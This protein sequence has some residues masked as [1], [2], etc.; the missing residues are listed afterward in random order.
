ME[1]YLKVLKL[2]VVLLMGVVFFSCMKED[3]AVPADNAAIE[4]RQVV[5]ASGLSSET[6]IYGVNSQ[7]ELVT[8]KFG[9][10]AQKVGSVPITGL[11]SG[12]VVTALDVRPRTGQLYGFTN[13]GNLYIIDPATGAATLVSKTPISPDLLGTVTAASFDPVTDQLRIVT[14]TG[15]NYTIDPATGMV[16]SMD[17]TIYPATAKINGIAYGRGSQDATISGTPLYAI[18]TTDGTL[19]MLNQ[20]GALTTIGST[21]WLMQG[22]GGFDIANTGSYALAVMNSKYSQDIYA[23]K[24]DYLGEYA[25]RLMLI[26][27]RS[28]K[29]NY[30]GRTEPM[31]AMAI[32]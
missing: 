2:C 8:Y 13:Q 16:S 29:V 31:N 15:K 23:S 4:E 20:K 9:N 1:P 27:L 11:R 24:T 32:K 18:N 30:F 28:G 14:E 25:S 19:A 12:E 17:G 6:T 7:N 21:G 5:S 22:D 10:P 3:L 26:D